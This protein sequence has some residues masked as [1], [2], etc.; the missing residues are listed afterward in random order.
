MPPLTD[1]KER[2]LD[3]LEK[4]LTFQL[5]DEPPTP[6]EKIKHFSPWP[7]RAVIDGLSWLLSFRQIG[8]FKKRSYLEAER[9]EGHIWPEYA[10]TMVGVLRLRQLREAVE[11][12]IRENIPGDLIET[13]VWRGGSCI[14]M[15]GVLAAHG[16]SDRRV[17]VADSFEGLPPPDPRRYPEDEGDIHHQHRALAIPE[18]EVRENFAKY[19]LLD[20]QVVFLKGWF[21]ET[22]PRL[23]DERFAVIRLDGDMYGSTIVA[24]ENLYPRLS[25]GG[26]CI[27]DDYALPGCR[28]AVED[29]RQAHGIQTPIKVIDWMGIYW[30]KE[31]A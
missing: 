31:E 3:L 14:W 15:R 9:L 17:F 8:L 5:W 2:Y 21:E 16:V 13:G 24:L 30:R 27:I 4:T 19:H 12:V 29:Y 25:R 18:S 7:V 28:K 26:F 1:P 11:T 10:H 6:I 23:T 20:D 22:L